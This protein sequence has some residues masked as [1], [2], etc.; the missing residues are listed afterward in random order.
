MMGIE[1]RLAEDLKQTMKSGDKIAL[2]AIRGVRAQ[3]QLT[4][5][6]RDESLSE[7][8]IIEILAREVKKR[9]ESIALY[10]QGNRMDLADNEKREIAVIESYLPAA[11][12][13]GEIDSIIDE[14]VQE[15]GA[16]SIKELGKVMS[17]LMPKIKGRA[18]GRAVQERVKKK[19][20]G[21]FS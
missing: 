9:R 18:D 17:I 15:S 5:T 16:Q 10:E 19:L 1:A 4:K 12:S 3:I 20:G 8:R 13:E 7:E 6:S 11:L 21:S 2:E 14:S